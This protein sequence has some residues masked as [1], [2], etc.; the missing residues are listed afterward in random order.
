MSKIQGKKTVTAL[1]L[2]PMNIPIFMILNSKDS[3]KAAWF[4]EISAIYTWLWKYGQSPAHTDFSPSNF[5][6]FGLYLKHS[7]NLLE[8]FKQERGLYF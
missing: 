8:S 5:K 4:F 6:K 7:E 1:V 3:F 2:K